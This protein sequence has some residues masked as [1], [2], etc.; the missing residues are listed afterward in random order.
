MSK[1]QIVKATKS[2][3]KSRC[4]TFSKHHSFISRELCL[5]GLSG[6]VLSALPQV[7]FGATEASEPPE[8]G[9]IP[10]WSL[11]ESVLDTR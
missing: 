6:K 1:P 3:Y 9:P 7:S 4:R 2:G 10:S 11:W 8:V 5:D